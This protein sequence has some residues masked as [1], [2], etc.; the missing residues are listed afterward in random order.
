[1]RIDEV[2]NMLDRRVGVKDSFLGDGFALPHGDGKEYWKGRA[3]E[4]LVRN[5][6]DDHPGVWT[7]KLPS[8]PE[9]LS[10]NLVNV[11]QQ[12]PIRGRSLDSF[13][14]ELKKQ[15]YS[16]EAPVLIRFGRFPEAGYSNKL[17]QESAKRV[18]HSLE[19]RLLLNAGGCG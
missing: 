16:D 19:R 14:A 11:F 13:A 17:G 18:R 9:K 6:K 15:L 2:R 10:W 8:V 3:L 5:L 4:Y 12:Q 7:W 1:M